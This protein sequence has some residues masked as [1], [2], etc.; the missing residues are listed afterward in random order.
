MHFAEHL[1][2]SELPK[3][4]NGTLALR[5]LAPFRLSSLW[6]SSKALF[7]PLPSKAIF[8]GQIARDPEEPSQAGCMS[9]DDKRPRSIPIVAQTTNLTSVNLEGSHNPFSKF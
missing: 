6:D 2:S 4:T 8:C 1:L 3:G 5:E 7:L 9:K